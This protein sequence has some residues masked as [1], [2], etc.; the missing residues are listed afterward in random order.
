[1]LLAIGAFNS[2]QILMLSGV[3]SAEHLRSLGIAVPADLPV[4]RN[5]QD[6]L[7]TYV[8]HWRRGFGAFPSRGR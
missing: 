3:G 6:H 1:M 5:L 7:G 4:G 2:P 8:T